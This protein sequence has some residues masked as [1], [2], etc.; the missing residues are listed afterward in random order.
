MADQEDL[1]TRRDRLRDIFSDLAGK[2]EKARWAVISRLDLSPED[3]KELTSL[4]SAADGRGPLDQK[5]GWTNAEAVD[6]TSLPLDTDIGAF[7]IAAL[8]GRGG[9]GEVYRA[10]RR[11]GF[12]QTVALKVL[13]P[14]ASGR[15]EAF[16]RERDVLS[17]LEHPG[18]ARVVD[19]GLA[20]DGRAWMAMEFV[21]GSDIT[22]W[23]AGKGIGLPERLDLFL[24]VCDSVAY[25]HRRLV[26][27]RDLKPSN[28]LVDGDGRTRLLDF[29][30]ARLL[31]DNPVGQ[32]L[33]IPV[34]TP[35]YAAPEQLENSPPTTAVDIYALGA[36]LFELMTGPGPWRFDDAPLPVVMR[37]LLHDDPPVPS[38]TAARNDAAPFEGR[39]LRGDLDAIILKAL[40]RRP[41]DRYE[42]VE[43]LAGDVRRYLDHR[44]V[45][46]RDGSTLYYASRLARRYRWPLAASIAAVAAILVGS[47]GI[48]FQARET[49]IE[50]D[51]ARAQA[52][53]ADAVSQSVVLMFRTASD[54]GRGG[55]ATIRELLDTSASQLMAAINPGDPDQAAVVLALADLYTTVDD[56]AAAETFVRRA[57]SAGVGRDDPATT[58]RLRL[59]L[60]GA[61]VAKSE[62]AE[63]E[64]LLAMVEPIW[65]ADPQRFRLERLEAIGMTAYMRRLQGERE[66][67][68]ALLQSILPDA[69]AVHADGSRELLTHYNNLVTHLVESNRIEEADTVLQRAEASARRARTEGMPLGLALIQ[70]RGAIESRKGNL[71]AAAASFGR[72]VALR[73]ELYGPSAALA[74]DR[75]NQ[76]RVLLALMRPAEAIVAFDEAQ[77]LAEE[78]LGP[79]TLLTLMIALSRIDALCQLERPAEA[80][81]LLDFAD[82]ASLTYGAESL[83]RGLFHRTR[84]YVRLQQQRYADVRRDLAAAER[85]YGLQGAAGAPYMADVERL[86]SELP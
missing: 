11:D 67:G 62:F 82:R 2:S 76:G 13:R 52:A 36:V 74:V 19:G 14:E 18:I 73:R 22:L 34:L 45:T 20:P 59:K 9:A 26:V 30:V 84:A 21:E 1:Q 81:R 55:T 25:A 24:Q 4:L 31:V 58:A 60:A 3:Q 57:L 46:A 29:G 32:T 79:D 69:E 68:I 78:Y 39:R 17:S 80:E 6:Y 16:L 44:P 41:E 63:T 48:A 54:S 12:E 27:H 33:T 28:I 53:R 43:A 23:T 8:L 40:R 49:A 61:L 56:L 64:T 10:E 72:A 37:R 75:M 86:R 50:R 47:A 51:L 77:P 35:E 5:T 83:Q 15:P 7:R 42:S 71:E 38:E 85:I 70:S 66:E 65:R